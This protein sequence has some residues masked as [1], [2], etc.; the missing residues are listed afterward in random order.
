[1]ERRT[2][3]VNGSARPLIVDPEKSLAD[4]LRDQLLMTGCKVCC[5][6][7][8]CGACT[9]L[10][11]GKPIRACMIPMGEGGSR[12]QDHHHRRHRHA[13]ES[14]SAPDR[15]DGPR[16]RAVRCLLPRASSCRPRC[17][18][19]TTSQP[20]PRRRF[21]TGSN[22]IATL[23]RCT[24]YKP[25]IDAVMDAASD[26][27]RREEAGDRSSSSRGQTGR[28]LGTQ[29]S[30]ARRPWPRSPAPGTSAPTL[31]CTCRT[32]PCAWRWSRP[33][34][35]TPTSRASTPR[36]PRRCPAWSRSSPGRT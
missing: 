3:N 25:L 21:A 14:A 30:R 7:G 32:T 5:D 22:A 33:R 13:G 4:V 10:V 29:V 1:M 28:I 23:C 9:V 11:D 31:P 17:C 12:R 18:S 6:E 15:L 20:D 26:H 34:S 16:R 36:K 27:A 24:G 2:L 35:R 19:T 8:Q